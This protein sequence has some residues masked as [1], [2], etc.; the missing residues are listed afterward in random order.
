MF[1]FNYDLKGNGDLINEK[2]LVGIFTTRSRTSYSRRFL[3]ELHSAFN[4][5]LVLV[6]THE[7]YKSLGLE[8]F[9]CKKIIIYDETNMKYK[10]ELNDNN[11]LRIKI[12]NLPVEDLKL[13]YLLKDIFISE[14]VKNIVILEATNYSKNLEILSVYC[15]DRGINVFCLPG[16]YGDFSSKGTNR[17]IFNGAIPLFSLDL[18]KM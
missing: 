18:L 7:I 9:D 11:I 14:I 2:N 15:A 10:D 6:M 17:M 1:N 5:S 13:R 12:N 16:R 8:K 4:S 3:E